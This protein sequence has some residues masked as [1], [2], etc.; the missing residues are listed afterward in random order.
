VAPA[1]CLDGSELDPASFR[2]TTI[3]F[4]QGPVE[5]EIRDAEGEAILDGDIIL[6]PIDEIGDKEL[7]YGPGGLRPAGAPVSHAALSHLNPWPGGRIPFVIDASLPDAVEARIQQAISDWNSQTVVR[8]VPR[9]AR[10]NE[11]FVRFTGPTSDMGAGEGRSAI[12]YQPGTNQLIRLGSNVSVGTIRHEIGHTVGLFHEQ[13]R[14]DRDNFIRINM[15]EVQ[16]GAEGNFETYVW[17][18]LVGL[19]FGAY[20][21]NSLMH[22][23]SFTFAAGSRPVIVR[24]GCSFTTRNPDCFVRP[25]SSLT[26]LDRKGV[27]RLVSGDP[28]FKFRIRNE[29]TNQCLRPLNGSTEVGA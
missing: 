17:S 19:D 13:S 5:L 21:L 8:L 15:N 1:A 28:I 20:D 4:G 24:A 23:G 18:G 27:T 16:E 29:A 6:G 25:S 9:P 11:H 2:Y 26:E 14:T 3:D 12:G 10:S 7:V 22:Y